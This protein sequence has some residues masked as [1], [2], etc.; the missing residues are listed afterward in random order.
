ML[1][2]RKLVWSRLEL[3]DLKESELVS[4][5]NRSGLVF[6]EWSELDGWIAYILLSQATLGTLSWIFEAGSE[7][8]LPG[9][10]S[11]ST[12]RTG[13]A[14]VDWKS[15]RKGAT[16]CYWFVFRPIGSSVQIVLSSFR[17]ELFGT[18]V[19]VIVAEAKVRI[20]LV[21]QLWDKLG[22][23]FMLAGM[24]AD[25]SIEDERQYRAPHLPVDLVVSRYETSG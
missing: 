6:V 11:N 5:W 18:L 9:L 3:D 14:L 15:E 23:T 7:A 24:C 21:L 22:Y 10:Q 20:E 1:N 2:V 16:V 25:A 19:V 17:S 8:S 4:A 13:L 12:V